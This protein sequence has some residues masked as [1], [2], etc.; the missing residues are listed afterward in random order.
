LIISSDRA[1]SGPVKI[2]KHFPIVGQHKSPVVIP[3]RIS[4]DASPAPPFPSA[5]HSGPAP[6]ARPRKLTSPL[7]PNRIRPL[8]F[9]QT[10]PASG[11]LSAFD[12]L[13]GQAFFHPRARL[14][15]RPALG[16]LSASAS[17]RSLLP[18]RRGSPSESPTTEAEEQMLVDELSVPFYR[19]GI[20][21]RALARSSARSDLE[22]AVPGEW[23]SGSAGPSE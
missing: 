4:P 21:P 16:L 2:E 5:S 12:S 22:T 17:G 19:A 14:D 7:A 11:S 13:T 10:R 15:H 8:A 1:A 23:D 20:R 6:P 18:L 3:D 9:C